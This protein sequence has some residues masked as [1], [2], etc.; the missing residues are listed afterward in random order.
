MA[1]FNYCVSSFD[2]TGN[3]DPICLGDLGLKCE[4]LDRKRKKKIIKKNIIYI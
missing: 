1:M 4:I 3:R 2:V